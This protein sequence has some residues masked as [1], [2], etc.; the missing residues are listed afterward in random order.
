MSFTRTNIWRFCLT[1]LTVFVVSGFLIDHS[2]NSYAFAETNFHRVVDDIN[3]NTVNRVTLPPKIGTVWGPYL[4]WD[5]NNVSY[6]G[7]PYDL[8]A[9]ATFTHIASGETHTTEMFYDGSNTWKFRFTA[10]KTG[11][12][13]VSTSS[14]DSD[15]NGHTGTITINPN[16]NSKM[17]GFVTEFSEKWGRTATEEAFI[18]QFVMVSGP[19]GYYNNASQID[20]EIQTFFVQHG[21]NGFHTMVMCRWFDINESNCG[22]VYNSGANSNP[23]P[24][25]R[26][27]EAL[28]LLITKVYENGG[29][30]HIWAWGDNAH[31]QTPKSTWGLNGPVDQRLQRYIAARLGPLPGL[32]HGLRL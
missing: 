22:T 25:T 21:F 15:L 14:S 11:A 19:Q 7:N 16:N 29:V 2:N 24:D 28:E 30:V 26:T 23:N 4:E 20:T 31:G 1:I 8:I 18:P 32:D 6:S 12:W 17:A 3:V 5:L 13:T 27:F 10:T 9:T